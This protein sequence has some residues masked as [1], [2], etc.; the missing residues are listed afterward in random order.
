LGRIVNNQ[1]NHLRYCRTF[2]HTTVDTNVTTIPSM[3][4][5]TDAAVITTSVF[6]PHGIE[7]GDSRLFVVANRIPSRPF[8]VSISI[9]TL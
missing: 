7:L 5:A 8:D 3:G 9:Q 2:N 1:T 4:V 6:I